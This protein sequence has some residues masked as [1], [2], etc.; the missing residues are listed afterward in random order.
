MACALAAPRAGAAPADSLARGAR[1]DSVVRVLPANP[2]AGA[3]V[4]TTDSAGARRPVRWSEQP[5][6]IML[7]SLAVPGWGQWHNHAPVK[8]VAIAGVEGWIVNGIFADQRAMNRLLREANAAQAAE[9]STA[10]NRA[11]SEYNSHLN[12]FVSGQ[13][14]VAGVLAY[15]M[16]DAYVD[17]HFRTFDIDF[18]NDPALPRDAAPE[19]QPPGGA[20]RASSAR[21]SLRWHF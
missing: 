16:I 5:R 19:G 12:G 8:A 20:R 3:G 15:A 10:Y 6:F 21:L 13:W 4:A 7:R 2:D 17:A 11:A 1:P 14:L 9:D 18:R